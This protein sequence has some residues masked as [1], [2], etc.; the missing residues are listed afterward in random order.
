[1]QSLYILK[2]S[3]DRTILVSVKFREYIT[4]LQQLLFSLSEL[5]ESHLPIG[6]LEDEFF[7]SLTLSGNGVTHINEVTLRQA[8]LV[9]GWVT[10]SGSIPGAV[11]LSQ[12]VTSHP[13]QHSLAIPS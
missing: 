12:Y 2:F 13:R 10:V 3:P 1:M 4:G 8:R 5:A 11:H 6:H 9:L 7:L